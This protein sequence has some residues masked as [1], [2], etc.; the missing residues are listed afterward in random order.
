MLFLIINILKNRLI[1][2][3]FHFVRKRKIFHNDLF[4]VIHVLQVIKN[5][6]D[7]IDLIRISNTI[8]EKDIKMYEVVAMI[9]EL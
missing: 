1:L 8:K 4:D 5:M 9:Y 6:F 7:I 2:S 3:C